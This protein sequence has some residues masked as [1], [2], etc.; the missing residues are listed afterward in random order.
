MVVMLPVGL[1]ARLDFLIGQELLQGIR[2]DFRKRLIHRPCIVLQALQK[3][4]W[5]AHVKVRFGGIFRL[6]AVNRANFRSFCP[7][8][9]VPR[10]L[11]LLGLKIA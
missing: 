7:D 11:A 10:G 9:R 5:N 4:L 6:H 8:P 3:V 1:R 2:H